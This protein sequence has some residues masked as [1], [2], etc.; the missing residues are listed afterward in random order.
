MVELTGFEVVGPAGFGAGGTAWNVRD[1]RG[2]PGVAIRT[3]ADAARVASLQ[4]LRHPGLPP[5][6]SVHRD[7]EGTIVVMGLVTGPTL[8]TVFGARAWARAGELAALW[9]DVSGALAALHHRGLVH[10]DVSPANI[11][12][13]DAGAPVLVDITGHGGAERGHHGFIPPEGPGATSPEAD[14]WALA[15]TL[16]W[17]SGDDPS[18]RGALGH[19]LAREPTERP[20]ARELSLRWHVLGEPVPLVMP[21]AP[22]LA[23]AGIRGRGDE[24]WLAPPERPRWW[25]PAACAAAAGVLVGAGLM[26]R[27][28]SPAEAAEGREDL[29]AAET[30]AELVDRRD[31]AV[32][33]NNQEA[34]RELYAP[35]SPALDADLALAQG[36]A[37]SGRTVEGFRTEIVHTSD[38]VAGPSEVSADLTLVQSEHVRVEADGSVR[39]VPGGPERCVAVRV[40]RGEDAWRIAAIGVCDQ[41]AAVHR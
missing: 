20:S 39:E 36:L 14:V 29:E 33:S 24:T 10:G 26:M 18:V 17:A 2:I 9:R 16:L 3:P 13:D 6:R 15:R 35:D 27:P 34:L 41:P 32:V 28:F 30:L 1:A 19:A 8:A 23:E 21:P 7:A 38:L 37:A 11:L 40:V 31:R 12:M 5:I 25:L 4:A 22:R